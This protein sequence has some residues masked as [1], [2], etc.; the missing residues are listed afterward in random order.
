MFHRIFYVLLFLVFL[1]VGCGPTITSG[2]IC[3]RK[4]VPEHEETVL[5]TSLDFQGNP[6]LDTDTQTVPDQWFLTFRR[7]DEKTGEWITRTVLV[8]QCVY[9]N[10]QMGDFFDTGEK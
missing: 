10:T 5:S 8:E 1:L 4:F 7:V 9:E 2:E 3:D 6:V